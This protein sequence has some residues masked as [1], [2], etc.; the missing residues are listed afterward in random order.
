[1]RFGEL[2]VWESLR[3]VANFPYILIKE[4]RTIYGTSTEKG[5]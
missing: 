4:V 1:M 5:T 2:P 3:I